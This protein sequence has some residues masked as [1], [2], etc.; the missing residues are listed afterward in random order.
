MDISDTASNSES[1][2]NTSPDAL[3]GKAQPSSSTSQF[4][5]SPNYMESDP[6]DGL[7]ILKSD[8]NSNQTTKVTTISSAHLDNRRPKI[9]SAQ[10][11][12]V[13][14]HPLMSPQ[15]QN[16]NRFVGEDF[17]DKLSSPLR[18]ASPLSGATITTCKSVTSSSSPK[19]RG[20]LDLLDKDVSSDSEADISQYQANVE[21]SYQSVSLVSRQKAGVSSPL[22]SKD[23]KSNSCSNINVHSAENS[24]PRQQSV[25]SV[26]IRSFDE[27]DDMEQHREFMSR[28]SSASPIEATAT[29]KDQEAYVERPSRYMQ[30]IV[31]Y[32]GSVREIDMKV[33]EP[34][35]RVLSHGGYL[36]EDCQNAI[37]IFSSC[38]LPDKSR[39]DYH[40]V[41]DS[42]FL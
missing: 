38:F 15:A 30:T 27:L 37:V 31:L 16:D 2:L 11:I 22:R 28:S 5:R 20:R 6:D 9:H 7:R 12:S 1:P 25:E 4:G 29:T 13:N 8:L 14:N 34:Y 39:A 23:G 41:M 32:D 18:L 24:M 40:Y 21:P 26:S 35:K 3:T 36:T 17:A 10:L 42:L 33:I 19:R